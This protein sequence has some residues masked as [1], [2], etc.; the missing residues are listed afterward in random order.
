[1]KNNIVDKIIYLYSIRKDFKH[2]DQS[3]VILIFEIYFRI[4]LNIF[5]K[6]SGLEFDLEE[7]NIIVSNPFRG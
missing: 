2:S 7:V 6:C 4:G 1:M 3:T 5:M